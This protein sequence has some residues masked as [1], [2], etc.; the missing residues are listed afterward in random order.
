MALI[1]YNETGGS[2]TDMYGVVG[3]LH[4]PPKVLSE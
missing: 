1:E 4:S 3:V 2:E